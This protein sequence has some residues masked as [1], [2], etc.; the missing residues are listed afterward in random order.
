[1]K[2]QHM[3]TRALARDPIG[4]DERALLTGVVVVLAVAGVLAMAE[5][6]VASRPPLPMPLLARDCSRL[7][8]SGDDA[9]APVVAAGVEDAAVASCKAGQRQEEAFRGHAVAGL[10]APKV[11]MC[12]QGESLG[13]QAHVRHVQLLPPC[14]VV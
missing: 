5:A 7:L 8:A 13:M 14:V 2:Q 1:M 3:R 12:A 9:A 11:G 4:V 10:A 6:A